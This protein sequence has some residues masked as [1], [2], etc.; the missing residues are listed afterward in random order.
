MQS[1]YKSEK[2]LFIPD[3]Q[4]TFKEARL[5]TDSGVFS[6]VYLITGFEEGTWEML[7]VKKDGEN[8]QLMVER[9]H[10]RSFSTVES[11][12]RMLGQLG[13]RPSSLKLGF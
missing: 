4:I 6:G 9:G 13:I 3:T 12:L 1:K 8:C 7:F 2:K 11:A 5:L 10:P